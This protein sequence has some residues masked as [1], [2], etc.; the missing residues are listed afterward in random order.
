MWNL[1]A[2]RILQIKYLWMNILFVV[3]IL[4]KRIYALEKMGY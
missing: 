1:L 3:D 4:L 2:L